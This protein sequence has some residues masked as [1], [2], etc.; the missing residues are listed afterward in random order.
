[1]SD[2]SASA[3]A[4]T[5]AGTTPVDAAADKAVPCDGRA[6]HSALAAV[7]AVAMKPKGKPPKWLKTR[8]DR[9]NLPKDIPVW[10]D[11]P[12]VPPLSLIHI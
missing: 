9:P 6:K 3:V 7:A 5:Q 2:S 10:L 12:N 8:K 11:L 4:S 1:M